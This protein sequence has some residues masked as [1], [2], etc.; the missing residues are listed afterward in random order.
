MEAYRQLYLVDSIHKYYFSPRTT[1]L[2]NFELVNNFLSLVYENIC[3]IWL[4]EL[5][6]PRFCLWKKGEENVTISRVICFWQKLN[7]RHSYYQI[8]HYQTYISN[9]NYY[10]LQM[11][12]KEYT[13]NVNM[14]NVKRYMR[15]CINRKMQ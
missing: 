6:L 10:I 11:N 12:F 15:N 3:D 1:N 8:I 14:C 7:R 5:P 2:N 9:I 4:Y 13:C